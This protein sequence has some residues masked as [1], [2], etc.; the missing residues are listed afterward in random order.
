[1]AVGQEFAFLINFST[2][3][4]Q[5]LMSSLTTVESYSHDLSKRLAAC[6]AIVMQL[7]SE[8]R[9]WHREPMNSHQCNPRIYKLDD[10]VFAWYNVWSDASKG[11]V[12]KLEFSFT[13]PWHITG[14]A[15]SGLYNI[16]H[17]HHPNWWM[18]KYTTDLTPYLAE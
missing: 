13:G 4:H 15:D 5:E 3:M 10:I 12:S 2:R 17:C 9:A 18:K 11:R 1:V 14:S 8:H 6:R 7:V 16:E